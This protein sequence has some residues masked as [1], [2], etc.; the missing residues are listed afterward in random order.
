MNIFQ[1]YIPYKK[2]KCSYCQSPCM[3]DKIKTCLS[4]RWKLTKFY[5]EHGQKKEDQ[6]KLQEKSAYC[7]EEILKAKNNYI[8]RLTS[9]PNDPKAAPKTY[10]SILIWFLYNKKIS[11]IPPLLVNDKFISEFLVKT[12]LFNDFFVSICT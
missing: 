6:E 8:I 7:T 9:K 2:V 3:N 10:W 11:S 5:Y 4:E 1:N 12:N